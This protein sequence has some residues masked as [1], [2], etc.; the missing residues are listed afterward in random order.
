MLY[1][2]LMFLSRL[3]RFLP[4]DVL[5]FIG[6]I[7]G[8]IYY[9]VVKKQRN[10]AIEQMMPALKISES[11]AKKI[12]RASFVNLARNMLDILYMPNLTP[13]NI[14]KYVEFDHIERI[15]EAINER[16]GV[17]VVTGHIGTWEWMSGA[18]ALK[19]FP[20]TAIA[21]LQPNA[22]YSRA[23]DDLRATVHVEI[24]TR[25]TS[26]LLS[27]G[28]ALKKGKILGFLADQ[29]GG[30]GGAFIDFLG[31]PASTPMGAAVFARK[32]GSPVLPMFIIRQPNGRHKVI[33]HEIMRYEDSGDTDKD[34][35]N[36]T[37]K[38]TKIIEN[39]ILEYPTQWLW[40]Q[41]RWNTPL[42]MQKKNK[43]HSV[44]ASVE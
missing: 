40:F 39:V 11:E 14:D 9:V 43:H 21:K 36:F 33:V 19:G 30:A 24:F 35:Y 6:K 25:G 10:R 13:D 15:E 38:M 32:F 34:L 37:E 3:V 2:T 26:E 4:Y 20:V 22:E 23:L 17:V 12:V 44:K 7:L 16:H 31:K 42:E 28:R 8:N 27:A 18:V 5:L 41:K 1:K 29:D